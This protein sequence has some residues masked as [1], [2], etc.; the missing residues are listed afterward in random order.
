MKNKSNLAQKLEKFYN[1][2]DTLRKKNETIRL[3][4][5]LEFQQ[6][7]IKKIN[8]K[9]NMEMFSTKIR[10]GKA[11]IAEQKIRQLKKI[12]LKSKRLHKATSTKRFDPRKTIAR[13]VNNLNK[14]VSEKYGISPEEV[15]KKSIESEIFKEVYD[16]H[17][18][19]KV[20]KDAERYER[21]DISS[22]KKMRKKLRDPLKIGKKVLVLAERIRKKD[23]P[24]KLYKSTTENFS[25]FNRE[26]VF[27]IRK[28]LLKEKTFYYWISE[29]NSQKNLESKFLRQELFALKKQFILKKWI[30]FLFITTI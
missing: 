2:I 23:A 16:F 20:N 10:G 3:Q 18:L 11:F 24:G 8:K 26:K 22:D 7:E 4:T 12:L 13:S 25:F 14:T 9:Y 29:E 15:E 19:K 28:V 6:N 30:R 1:D 27:I 5:D 21:H 17:R